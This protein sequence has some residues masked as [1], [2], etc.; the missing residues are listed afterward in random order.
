MLE[1]NYHTI[2]IYLDNSLAIEIKRTGIT[3]KKLVYSGLLIL[4]ISKIVIYELWYDYM[5][6]KYGEKK[7]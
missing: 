7:N 3:M 4:E 6:P 2:G 5:K 1:P